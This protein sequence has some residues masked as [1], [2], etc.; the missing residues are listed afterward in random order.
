MDSVNSSH[1]KGNPQPVESPSK[2][3]KLNLPSF[4]RLERR[5]GPS[6][7]TKTPPKDSPPAMG[8]GE[9]DM[10][11]SRFSAT[12]KVKL[13]KKMTDELERSTKKKPPSKLKFELIYVIIDFKQFYYVSL[14]LVQTSRNQY[15][16]SLNKEGNVVGARSIFQGLR[17]DLNKCV[18]CPK[19]SI[20]TIDLILLPEMGTP[21][22]LL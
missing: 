22:S 1:S 21:K 7:I 13:E 10:S 15:D 14:T 2:S 20:C 9:A 3:S 6:R 16:A 11:L 5:G 18:F 17:A 12:V 19:V 8:I 4:L